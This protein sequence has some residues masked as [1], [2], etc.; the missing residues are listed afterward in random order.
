M[1]EPTLNDLLEREDTRAAKTK[2]E[3]RENAE[4]I[5]A[6]MFGRVLDSE[7]TDTDEDSWVT[8]YMDL[9]TLLLVLFVILLANADLSGSNDQDEFGRMQGQI[10]AQIA[11]AGFSDNVEVSRSPGKINI[12]L[13]DKILF[14]SGEAE[15]NTSAAQVM[16]PIV[17][18]LA[19]NNL[20]ISVEGHTDNVPISTLQFPSNWELS[21]ARAISVVRFLQQQGIDKKRLRAIGYAD[22]LPLQ[23]N[24]SVSGRAANRRVNLVLSEAE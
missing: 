23:S 7:P 16:T 13:N 5:S 4:Q 12:R 18:L 15:F 11:G 24:E 22:S 21:A 8:T 20:N 19:R 10:E 3:P 17:E 9:L 2:R 14:D 6:R 1:A